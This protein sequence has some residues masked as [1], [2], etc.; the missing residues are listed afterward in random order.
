MKYLYLL[1]CCSVVTLSQAQL[2]LEKK[3]FRAG[4][5]L[6]ETSSPLA[7]TGE[8]P[9][10][11]QTLKPVLNLGFAGDFKL[12]TN[13]H[14][15]IGAQYQPRGYSYSYTPTDSTYTKTNLS[16]H[17]LDVPVSLV[18]T[19]GGKKARVKPY[20][21]AGVYAGMGI[22]GRNI[23]QNKMVN[24]K[25]KRADSTFTT[26]T[27]VFGE[28][29]SRFDYG[30]N[31]SVGIQTRMVQFGARYS[32]GLNDI[33]MQKSVAIRNRVFGVFLNILFDDMF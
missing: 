14:L 25:T 11:T 12:S 1:I 5:S 19:A 20:L 13:I 23:Q 21:E 30:V 26:S 24:P 18:L 17:Y 3:V 15:H 32:M 29:L 9:L 10:G 33:S 28:S 22:Y 7:L 4:I 8:Q 6:V 31:L 27:V 2:R 16:L